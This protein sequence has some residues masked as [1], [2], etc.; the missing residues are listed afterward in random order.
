MYFL[1]IICLSLYEEEAVLHVW[2]ERRTFLSCIQMRERE[3]TVDLHYK[4]F[5][6]FPQQLPVRFVFYITL[7][8]LFW[9]NGRNG[10]VV[11][12]VVLQ[13]KRIEAVH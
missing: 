3:E 8:L 7:L 10:L 11:Y 5:R 2:R 6:R 4:N 13:S 9:K 12:Y 1:S